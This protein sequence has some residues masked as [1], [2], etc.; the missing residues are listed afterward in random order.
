HTQIL[1]FAHIQNTGGRVVPCAVTVVRVDMVFSR[2][3]SARPGV[4]PALK[5]HA[6][7]HRFTV[8]HL[9]LLAKHAILRPTP[10][11]NLIPTIGQSYIGL[12]ATIEVHSAT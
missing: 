4:G 3:P 8:L 7:A 11:D 5:L 10:G 12:I 2:I 9:D 1:A 6:K